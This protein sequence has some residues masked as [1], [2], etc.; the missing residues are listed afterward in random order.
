M[1]G[2][3]GGFSS[4]ATPHGQFRLLEGS[5]RLGCLLERAGACVLVR[6]C[7][8]VCVC[9]RARVYTRESEAI[10]IDRLASPPRMPGCWSTKRKP[11]N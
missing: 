9:V 10:K 3:V 8:C 11:P 1:E 6:A 2:L 5:A 4:L 7:V